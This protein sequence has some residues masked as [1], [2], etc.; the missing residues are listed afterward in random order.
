MLDTHCRPAVGQKVVHGAG[1]IAVGPVHGFDRTNRGLA[2]SVLLVNVRRT[3]RQSGAG[4]VV[5][6]VRFAPRS[7]R[8]ADEFLVRMNV[9]N[10]DSRTVLPVNDTFQEGCCRLVRDRVSPP[11][12]GVTVH[13]NK[14]LGRT[15]NAR[16]V[17]GMN[18]HTVDVDKPAS[19]TRLPVR[20]T[21]GMN[22]ALVGADHLAGH[23]G[24]AHSLLPNREGG[25]RGSAGVI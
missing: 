1:V 13:E 25:E 9:A 18:A 14:G 17:R 5:E 22:Q 15:V 12:A 6:V 4:A 19:L 21:I 7:D 8:L 2:G 3:G 10:T 16:L 20:N 24:P 23:A 11:I